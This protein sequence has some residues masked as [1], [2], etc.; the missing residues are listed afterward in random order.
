MQFFCMSFFSKLCLHFH[1]KMDLEVSL[2]KKVYQQVYNPTKR[3]HIQALPAVHVQVA[4]PRGVC[5]DG[6]K[7]LV[8]HPRLRQAVLHQED[9]GQHDGQKNLRQGQDIHP[10]HRQA[11]L[12]PVFPL[13]M[14]IDLVYGDA[15]LTFY[16]RQTWLS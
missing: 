2:V 9:D 16:Q 8:F 13:H 5:Q 14:V 10:R 1:L 6:R 7:N 11:G 3:C 12:P 15:I 4:E